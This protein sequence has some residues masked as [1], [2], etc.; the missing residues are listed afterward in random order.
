MPGADRAIL[1]VDLDAFFASVEQLDDP[2][3]RGRPVV[4]GGTG[5]RGVVAAASYEARAFG[6]RSAMPVAAARRAC[7][8][9]VF[10]AP[11]P[12]RYREASAA[13]MAI[14]GTFSPLVEQLSID[15][16]FLD[17]TGARRRVGE[18]A[19]VGRRL[20]EA[21]AVATGLTASVGIA[22]TKFLAKV[23][24]DL[25]KPDGL[26]EVP[27]AGA[28]AF[29]AP[30]PVTRC[31][32][33]GPATLARLERLG[34]TRIGDLVRVGAAGL[35][36]TL[37]AGLAAH[38]VALARNDDPRPVVPGGAA[39][40]IGAEETFA[41]D[42]TSRADCDRELLRLADR[43]A[44]RLRSV[45]CT[46]RTVTLKIRFG[47]F[48]TR[49][50]ARTLPEATAITTAV[51]D[52]ARSLLD[53]FDPGRGVRLLG[54]TASN[55]VE[56]PGESQTELLVDDDAV[57]RAATARRGVLDRAVDEVRARYGRGAV[58]PAVLLESERG[59][60]R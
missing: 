28:E 31:W 34:V 13:V 21:I 32:G 36:P 50:R 9:A 6:V 22:S 51:L 47:D 8:G 48:E 57:H 15:E 59:P 26:L 3:L 17:V 53:G 37:G 11:R 42:L 29:L 16:A 18:P 58:Q 54:I 38:L 56:G 20:R 10:V 2:G 14:V 27:A 39:K 5:G 41:A 24:S 45:G 33:V 30:L 25:A 1:H 46:A 44:G 55:L 19:E 43:V 40:S 52:A 49:T 4:V 23:A 7:P 60:G 12:G 35:E